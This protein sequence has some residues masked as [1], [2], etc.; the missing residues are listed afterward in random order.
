MKFIRERF[1]NHDQPVTYKLYHVIAL[2]CILQA[3]FS[4]AVNIV[5]SSS[6]IC[7]VVYGLELVFGLAMLFLVDLYKG[8]YPS[9]M[10][11]LLI[12]SC[13]LVPVGFLV[14]EHTGADMIVYFTM[15]I[16]VT[17][18]ALTG[19]RLLICLIAELA[20]YS[21]CICYVVLHSFHMA[22]FEL[23]EEEIVVQVAGS[24]LI[25]G[26]VCAVL[27]KE[28]NYSLLFE[29]SENEKAEQEAKQL[30]YAKDM[31]LVNVSHDIRT[32]LHAII[33]TSEMI[34]EKDNVSDDIRKEAYYISNA[35][36]ALLSITNDLL[37]FSRSREEMVV[38]DEEPYRFSALLQEITN[39]VTVRMHDSKVRFIT[40]INP[41]IPDKLYGDKEKIRSI[42]SN[43]LQNA[44]KFTAVGSIELTVEYEMINDSKVMIKCSVTDTGI[45]MKPEMIAKYF[46]DEPAAEEDGKKHKKGG[47]REKNRDKSGDIGKTEVTGMG[48]YLCRK[49]LASMGGSIRADSIYG[50]GSTFHF[51]FVQK[52]ES[53]EKMQSVKTDNKYALV[54]ELVSDYRRSFENI[55]M[56]YG[57]R[58]DYANSREE[59]VS[60]AQNPQY[61][62]I[63]VPI[64]NYEMCSEEEK[65][66]INKMRLILITESF[67][68]HVDEEA[69]CVCARPVHSLNIGAILNGN[70]NVAV[71]GVSHKSLYCPDVKALVVDD[72]LINLD[73]ATRLLKRYG[74]EITAVTSGREGINMLEQEDFDILFLDYMMPGM[75]GIDTLHHIRELKNERKR[76]IPA[77]ALTANAVSGAKE[78][79]LQ[80]GFDEYVSKPIEVEHLENVMLKLLPNDRFTS[81]QESTERREQA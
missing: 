23:Y 71:R 34:M 42:F 65:A 28:R 41:N 77:V 43:I 50:D 57:I 80:A 13:V 29:I 33:G 18:I 73:V 1:L 47:N 53:S 72:N 35:G 51:Q 63:F 31:F 40:T 52:V 12:F 81:I 44:V 21:A 2:A 62:H 4:L 3:G 68:T 75:D 70:R 17:T 14:K 66:A 76:N 38:L 25:A 60:M 58:C 69:F 8:D 61:S 78:M 74:C 30:N 67:N 9:L 27:M 20:V 22:M 10:V 19:I 56:Y 54:F 16:C 46:A 11:L 5:F 26:C 32:P 48:I 24:L 39:I 37:D 36:H 6:V 64:E 79:F 45:G 15:C 55:M 7:Y 59:F 49:T